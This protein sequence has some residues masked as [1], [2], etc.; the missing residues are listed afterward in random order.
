MVRL[1]VVLKN[2]QPI[3]VFVSSTW[4]TRAE[5]RAESISW[6]IP[7]LTQRLL[8]KFLPKTGIPT[9][10]TYRYYI[11]AIARDSKDE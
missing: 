4:V 10:V 9:R 5:S 1:P 7:V 2:L 3:L 8:S 6:V 11:N